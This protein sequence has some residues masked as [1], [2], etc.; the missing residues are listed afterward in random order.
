MFN[1]VEMRSKVVTKRTCA[2]RIQR[3]KKLFKKIETAQTKPYNKRRQKTIAT[4]TTR[5]NK[6]KQT[7]LNSKCADDYK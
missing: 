6:M 1:K 3:L 2:E 7:L 4:E 5:F